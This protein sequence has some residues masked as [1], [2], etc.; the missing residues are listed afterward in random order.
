MSVEND[1]TGKTLSR[2]NAPDQLQAALQGQDPS[3]WQDG[4]ACQLHPLVRLGRLRPAV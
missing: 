4:A 3:R 1:M 2:P